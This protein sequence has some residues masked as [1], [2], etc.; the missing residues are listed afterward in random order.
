M[1]IWVSRRDDLS[2]IS[3]NKGRQINQWTFNSVPLHQTD[4]PLLKTLKGS[5]LVLLCLTYGGTDDDT[6]KEVSN[7][8]FNLSN[9]TDIFV[10]IVTD[11]SLFSD[12][13]MH[14][15]AYG[16]P[17]SKTLAKLYLVL[18]DDLHILVTKAL[19]HAQQIENLTVSYKSFHQ[20]PKYASLYYQSNTLKMLKSRTLY[21]A[22]AYATFSRM[23]RDTLEECAFHPSSNHFLSKMMLGAI[24]KYKKIKMIRMS[25]YYLHNSASKGYLDHLLKVLNISRL[26][27]Y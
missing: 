11:R 26:P 2:K 19:E 10:N 7:M 18:Q 22:D 14:L 13:E 12:S 24:L 8:F 23:K 4:T 20:A 15:F 17:L 1:N 16:T 25:R 21:E 27:Y 9:F 6:R 5:R 3:L